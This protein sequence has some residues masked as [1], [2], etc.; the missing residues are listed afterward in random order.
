MSALMTVIGLSGSKLAQND[1]EK[2][3][4]IWLM[5]KDQSCIGLGMA[6]FDITEMPWKKEYFNEQKEFIIK[7]LEGIMDKVGWDTLDYEPN[8]E[9]ISD[10][11]H[12]LKEMFGKMQPED[13]NMI[14]V[15]EWLNDTSDT[16][17]IKTGC[18]KC[19]KHNIYLSLFGCIACN[20]MF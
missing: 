9:I 12:Q 17:P 4:I 6:G 16:E 20:D 13:I 5:E 18:P 10:K 1:F 7:V 8:M 14:A 2:T 15:N 3:F 11:V 19:K